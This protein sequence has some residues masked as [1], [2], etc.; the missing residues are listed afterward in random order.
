M[1]S[2]RF[3]K[4]SLSFPKT[5]GNLLWNY[6]RGCVKINKKNPDMADSDRIKIAKYICETNFSEDLLENYSH[7][8]AAL[9]HVT[10]KLEDSFIG[11]LFS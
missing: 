3:L 2:V 1:D 6:Y 11:F 9:V 8:N 7:P 5:V 4:G 10:F